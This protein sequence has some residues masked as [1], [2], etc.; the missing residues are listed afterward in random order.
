MT[1]RYNWNPEKNSKLKKERGI[2]FE[3]IVEAINAGKLLDVVEHP[4]Q[5]KYPGQLIYI[6]HTL[7]YIYL[8]PYVKDNDNLFLKTIIPSRKAKRDYL[9]TRHV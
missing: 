7:D 4:N 8:V 5:H 2:G 3:D 1:I 6:V 9:E